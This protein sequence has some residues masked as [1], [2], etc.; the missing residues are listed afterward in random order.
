MSN[1]IDNLIDG[2]SIGAL[3]G[4]GRIPASFD[5][6][7]ADNDEKIEQQ[8]AVACFEQA[9]TYMGLISTIKGSSLKRLTQH[10][11]EIYDEFVKHF[12]ELQSDAR[13]SK[14]SENE[15]KSAEGKRRW[16][17]FMMPFE[18]KV[19]DYNFGT[20]IRADVNEDYTE[21]NSIFGYRTQFYAIEIARNRRGL[22][23]PIWEKAQ[24]GKESQA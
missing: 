11:D 19:D 17:E 13:L 7:Q 14:L 18:K 22:N 4:S 20:L 2:G 1:A 23:D 21:S 24:A 10:D 8:F 3:G 16:R 12:P 6:N 9:E 5:A 15:L